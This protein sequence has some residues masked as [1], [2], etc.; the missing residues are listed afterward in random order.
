MTAYQVMANRLREGWK[1]VRLRDSARNLDGDRV[2]DELLAVEGPVIALID[3]AQ[4]VPGDT[5]REVLEAA[6]SERWVLVVST[7]TVQGPAPVVRMAQERAVATL[8]AALS[9][10]LEALTREVSLLDPTVGDG[11]HQRSIEHRLRMAAQQPTPWQFC[12]VLSGGWHR[13]AGALARLRERDEAHLALAAIA[14]GQIATADAGS[15]IDR[16]DAMALHATPPA[17]QRC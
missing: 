3:D 1:P 12:F 2:V 16:L 5:L 15:P 10:D 8:Y 7:E 11:V 17:P 13:V 9:K 6:G 14:V 4:S